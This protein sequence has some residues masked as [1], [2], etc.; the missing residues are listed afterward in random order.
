MPLQGCLVNT[1]NEEVLL[2]NVRWCDGFLCKLRGLMFRRSLEP[3]EGLLMAEPRESK[4][5]V[6]IHML[7][8]AFPIATVWL[9]SQFRVVDTVY[10]KPW[11]LAYL[12]SVPAKYTLE[13]DVSLLERVAVGDILRFDADES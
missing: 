6:S 2:S 10:A 11:A 7:F 3:G 4:A 12:P 5:G 9:D 13:A 8:M 1:K